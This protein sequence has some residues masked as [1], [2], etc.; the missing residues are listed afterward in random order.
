[1][2]Y[3]LEGSWMLSWMFSILF[4]MKGKFNREESGEREK[5]EIKVPK[6]LEAAL[7]WIPRWKRKNIFESLAL[8]EDLLG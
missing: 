2:Y 1:V 4:G 7:C 8:C 3:A 6:H 5:Q